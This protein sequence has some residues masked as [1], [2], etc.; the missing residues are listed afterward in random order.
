MWMILAFAKKIKAAIK[1][2]KGKKIILVESFISF[3]EITES[4]VLVSF[5]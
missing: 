3:D 5:K 4:I 1:K 2:E